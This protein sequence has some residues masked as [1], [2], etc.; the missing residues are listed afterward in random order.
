[1]KINKEKE[2][3]LRQLVVQKRY[4]KAIV[5]NQ[6]LSQERAHTQNNEEVFDCNDKKK[7]E[8]VVQM[9]GK[10]GTRIK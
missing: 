7:C 4:M 5:K 3:R 1:M 6:A 10:A 2:L 9:G 8:R